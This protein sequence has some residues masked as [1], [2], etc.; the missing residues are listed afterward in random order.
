M[1][2]YKVIDFEDT[3]LKIFPRSV[4][5]LIWLQLGI[6]QIIPGRQNKWYANACKCLLIAH[7]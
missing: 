1:K 3:A 7:L 5:V 6:D 4:F 2:A